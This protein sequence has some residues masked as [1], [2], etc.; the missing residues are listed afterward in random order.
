[1]GEKDVCEI[2]IRSRSANNYQ[3]FKRMRQNCLLDVEWAKPFIH[4][5]IPEMIV[6]TIYQNIGGKNQV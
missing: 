2:R 3:A 4:R 1:M 5:S 6:K